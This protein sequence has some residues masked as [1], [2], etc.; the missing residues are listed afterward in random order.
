[1]LKS[2]K[3]TEIWGKEKYHNHALF[4]NEEMKQKEDVTPKV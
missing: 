3:K 1:M 2:L 4:L